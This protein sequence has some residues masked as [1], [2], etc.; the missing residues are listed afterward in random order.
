[1][2]TNV[3]QLTLTRLSSVPSQRGNSYAYRI[4]KADE[5]EVA[6]LLEAVE[7]VYDGAEDG[8]KLIY[9][10]NRLGKLNVPFKTAFRLNESRKDGQPTGNWY[11]N[12]IDTSLEDF[13]QF[14]D[15]IVLAERF[16]IKNAASAV[17]AFYNVKGQAAPVAAEPVATEKT[18]TVLENKEL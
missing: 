7:G 18:E 13:G 5:P 14:A 2:K 8:T 17:A 11:I 3:K 9:S 16:G 10:R 6:E 4:E 15:K 1:M 12:P